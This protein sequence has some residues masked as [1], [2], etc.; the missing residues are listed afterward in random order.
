[1]FIFLCEKDF[2]RLHFL[3]SGV[4]QDFDVIMRKTLLML[5]GQ[6]LII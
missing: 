1:M 6:P 4:G 3:D 5:S 2:V